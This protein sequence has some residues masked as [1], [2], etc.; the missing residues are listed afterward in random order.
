MIVGVRD[1]VEA[2]NAVSDLLEARGEYYY[3]E[4]TV[5]H[6]ILGPGGRSGNCEGCL[7]N[8]DEGEI[9]ESEFFPGDVG[10]GP[11]D[12]PPLHPHCFIAGT[13]VT[14]GGR[15]LAHTK[16]WYSGEIIILRIAGVDDIAVTPNHPILTRRGWIAAGRIEL[17]DEIL[18]C[19]MPLSAMR[20]IDPDHNQIEAAIENIPGSPLMASYMANRGVPVSPEAFHGDSHAHTKIDIVRTAR[21]LSDDF[22][23]GSGSADDIIN[24]LLRGTHSIRNPLP[25]DGSLAILILAALTSA[26]GIM[27]SRHTSGANRWSERCIQQ[28]SSLSTA[29]LLE[30][31]IFP[32]PQDATPAQSESKR[33]IEQALPGLMRFV[34]LKSIFKDYFS[35]HVFNLETTDSYYFANT[36][37]VHNCSCYVEYRDTRRR[38]YV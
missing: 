37:I 18:Q 8:A 13:N 24:G 27:G 5:K 15:I 38:V 2:V 1:L 20:L 31:E 34:K 11:V 7:E 6:W 21:S 30:T 35:G 10:L 3:E 29:M 17:T 23:K 26:N 4:I 12:E 33:D 16:R 14:P 28:Q 25:S 36:I 19:S 22:R 9:E 32:V